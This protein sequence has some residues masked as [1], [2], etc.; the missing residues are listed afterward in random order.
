LQKFVSGYNNTVRVT[1][2]VAASK[3]NDSNIIEIWK[4]INGEN[5]KSVRVV[6]PKYELGQHVRISRE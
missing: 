2:G 5:I 1:T 6:K 3:V 4:K